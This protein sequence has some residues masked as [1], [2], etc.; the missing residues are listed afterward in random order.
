[1]VS[2]PTPDGDDEVGGIP[3][4]GPT[5]RRILLGA[6]LKRLRERA[7]VARADAAY[8]IRGSDSKMSRL[9]A[10]KVSFKERDVG[11]LLKMYGLTDGPDR[12]RVI[13]MARESNKSG[14]WQRYNEVIPSWF[15]DY[16]GL[17][18]SASRI[19]SY[20][21]LFVPGLLQIPEYAR[22]LVSGGRPDA[23]DPEAE[24]RLNLRM[25]RQRILRRPDAPTFWAVIDEAVLRRPIGGEDVLTAQ[26]DHLLDMAALPSVVLQILPW[27]LSGYAAEHA[28]TMLRFAEPE[29]P[30]LVYLEE[31][32]GAFYLDKRP[33]VEDYTRV[34][35][36]LTIDALSPDDSRRHLTKLRAE[37]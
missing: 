22:A 35:D 1:M 2:S 4:A 9:E 11:D 18:A 34:M 16:V 33:D 6:M 27:H 8:E 32:T 20:E 14:W 28:F 19:Q 5:A 3:D 37:R 17:E 13:E 10:G 36:R 7:G 15:E 24:Q 29:L 26:I 21:L 12:D 25:Q 31:H 23:T 30:D